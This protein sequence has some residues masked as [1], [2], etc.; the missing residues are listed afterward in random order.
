[1]P[2]MSD[3][4][5]MPGMS[6]TPGMPGM[7]TTSDSSPDRDPG[8][9]V[10]PSTLS[11]SPS[12]RRAA[13][14]FLAR[15]VEAV[16]TQPWHDAAEIRRAGFRPM[17]I[18]GSHWYSRANLT[19]GVQFDPDRPEFLVVLSGHVYGEMFLSDSFSLH[20]PEPPGA[21]QMRWHYHRYPDPVCTTP[22]LTQY[23]TSTGRCRPGDRATMRSPLMTHVWVYPTKSPFSAMMMPDV[24]G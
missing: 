14:D 19:D 4:A 8:M 22:Y 15:V 23:M 6:G 1:M 16:H 24:H 9:V 20:A 18:D 13:A 17:Q 10:V 7:G 21:P 5:G 11:D 3:M 12:R 2:G